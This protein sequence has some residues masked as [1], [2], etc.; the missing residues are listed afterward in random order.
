MTEEQFDVLTDDGQATGEQKS[1]SAVHADGDWHRSFH[2]WIVKE[3]R[4]VLMQRRARTKDLEP[5]KLDVSVGGHFAA[6]ESIGEVL[7]EAD[8]ELG[9]EVRLEQLHYLHTR[10]AER[11]YPQATDRE[12]Q[13]VYVTCCERPLADYALNPKEVYVL[14]EL[15]IEG[16]IALYRDGSPLPAAGFD[17]YGRHNH[18][19][20]IEADLIQQARQETVV[21]LERIKAWLEESKI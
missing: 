1:R 19:L 7:R 8:E 3:G 18:A 4:Y 16:A 10:K 2:L 6:G 14:Y 11:T 15:P 12:F 17:C 9:L 5:N 20:L 21:V 13:E